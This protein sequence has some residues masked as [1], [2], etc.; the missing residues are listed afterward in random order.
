MRHV[1]P[2]LIAPCLESLLQ[3]MILATIIAT[4]YFVHVKL[5]G[6]GTLISN[7]IC[8]CD[9][10]QCWSSQRCLLWWQTWHCTCSVAAIPGIQA[11]HLRTWEWLELL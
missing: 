3:Q 1:L 4:K 10:S 6:V 8:E 7:S 5:Y 9:T 2:D 11:Y